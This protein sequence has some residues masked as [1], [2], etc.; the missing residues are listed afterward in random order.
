MAAKV[1]YRA[2]ID[3]LRAIA[4]T[5]VVLFH[6]GMPGFSG[7]FIGV[8]IFF[9][10]SGWLIT[11]ILFREIEQTQT[12]SIFDFYA[13]RI[14]RIF[15]SLI[16]VT[17]TTVVAGSLLLSAALFEV[18][19]L[20]KSAAAAMAFVANFYFL[21]STSDYFAQASADFP[22]LHTWSLAVEEQYYLI[23]PVLILAA[24]K[25]G[26]QRITDRI[27]CLS[28]IIVFTFSSLVLCAA[29]MSR[30]G[31]AAFFLPVTRA[32]ELGT[33]SALA[34]I[35]SRHPVRAGVQTVASIF[36][37]SLIV[38]GVTL[39]RYDVG[40]P[41]PWALVPV[42][43]T[44]LL[45]WSSGGGPTAKLLSMTPLVSIG[46]VS[47]AWYLWH[48]P[49]LSFAHILTLGESKWMM[50][51]LLVGASLILAYFTTWFLEIPI[52]FDARYRLRPGR[53]IIAGLTAG[54]L[55]VI[56]AGAVYIAAR[57]GYI[58]ADPR[59]AAAF[60]DRPSRQN[61]CLLL[62]GQSD[63]LIADCLVKNDVPRVI[64][65]GDSFADQWAPALERWSADH[66]YFAIEQ[67]TKAGCP[68]LLGFVPSDPAGIR[69]Q[70]NEACGLFS[71]LVEKRIVSL[72]LGRESFVFLGG[73]WEAY[74]TQSTKD[75]FVNFRRGLDATLDLLNALKLTAVIVLQPPTQK[76]PSPSCVQR[77]G[78]LHCMVPVREQLDMVGP[79]DS[80]IRRSAA[81]HRNVLLFDPI[82]VLCGSEVCPA[83][84]DGQI[85]YNDKVHLSASV[86]RSDRVAKAL[87]PLLGRT[88][89]T[90]QFR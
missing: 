35:V 73:N 40:F 76:Y 16:I 21:Y 81:L 90:S 55:V 22:L 10:I 30:W 87:Q 14:R 85:A 79:V 19:S 62:G 56:T 66:G 36:G 67:L 63:H 11:K 70:P 46:R 23:W 41:F 53:T 27:S 6:S 44:A 37:L 78:E 9:V 72:K 38:V 48:W 26:G 24:T 54:A 50:R 31:A 52:R 89:Q 42:S 8:D 12:I 28:V 49:L 33:G 13:R 43:G 75:F 1:P 47:Y 82:D 5:T 80:V 69:K 34:L 57:G 74:H 25:L 32:W 45:L 7:G 15:P 71:S 39:I 77:L 18:H 64:L 68:P 59:I 88:Q 61:L 84:L 20:S 65:W 58:D 29:L 83:V 51:G 17:L 2:D 3:G 60:T 4:V 86:A